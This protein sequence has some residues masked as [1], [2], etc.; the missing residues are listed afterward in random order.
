[1]YRKFKALKAAAVVALANW[2]I[3]RNTSASALF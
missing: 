1:V 3:S 2:I